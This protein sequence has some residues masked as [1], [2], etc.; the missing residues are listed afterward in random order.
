MRLRNR[1][2]CAALTATIATDLLGAMA[3]TGAAASLAPGTT[4][5]PAGGSGG[6]SG[7][8]APPCARPGPGQAGCFLEY[9]R[10]V[11]VNR[12]PAASRTSKPHGLTPADLRSAYKL[13]DLATSDQTVAVSIAFDTP[14]LAKFLATYRKEFGLPPCTVASGCFR[15]VNQQ[16]KATPAEPAGV[17]TG[18]DLEAT[19]DVSM[20]SVA[21]PHCK[22]LVVEGKSPTLQDLAATDATAARLGAQVISNSYGG[23][24]GADQ[25]PLEKDYSQP[26][27]TYVASSGD[28]GFTSAQF[29]ADVATVT[30]VGGTT[31]T[32]AAGRARGWAEAV[33]NNPDL[34]AGG[35]GCSAWVAKPSWQ[36][37]TH[38][39]TRTIA[40]ISAVAQNVPIFNSTFGG[41]V[42]VG[43]TSIA[44]PLVAGI[45]G[46]AGNGATRTA[47]DLYS[48]R[49]SFFDITKGN[50]AW[51]QGR[52]AAQICGRD[53]LCAA[54]TGYDAPTGLGTPDGISGF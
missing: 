51:L 22:I 53:Y 46:L 10:Q 33:W 42:T 24:E 37:D 49:K 36:H 32:K 11:G 15:Q 40:D 3:G 30:A 27:H 13:P 12:E 26:G 17:G 4:A 39:P 19:L 8:I 9:R 1:A 41:W 44:A 45:Y 54:K 43:G 18:W 25:V 29:P 50:N 28:F 35:S 23:A 48:H 7:F 34:G 16:G 5:R 2:K 6:S 31:L 21:C 38:C 52:T 20:I 14:D 47:A